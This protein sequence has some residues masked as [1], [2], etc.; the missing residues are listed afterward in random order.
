MDVFEAVRTVLAVRRYTERRGSAESQ[1]RAV[2]AGFR[3]AEV[4]IPFAERERGES[5]MSGDIVRE[6]LLRVTEWGLA[7]RRAQLKKLFGR[8]R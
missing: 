5:K 4:P 3:V 2:Q 6:A 7:H 8:R 1:G